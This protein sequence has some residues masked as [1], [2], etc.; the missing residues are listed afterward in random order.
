[1]KHLWIILIAINFIIVFI[2]HRFKGRKL[3][4]TETK[5]IPLTQ[6]FVTA[7]NHPLFMTNP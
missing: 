6:M 3:P 7:G 5:L 4:I 2:I 1:M